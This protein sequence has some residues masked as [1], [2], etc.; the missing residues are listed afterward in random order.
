M[1]V[2]SETMRRPTALQMGFLG[3]HLV[4]I[5]FSKDSISLDPMCWVINDGRLATEEKEGMNHAV[6]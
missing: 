4:A 5:I 3:R 1:E 2:I 6:S